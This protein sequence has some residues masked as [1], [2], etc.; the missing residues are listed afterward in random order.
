MENAK[1]LEKGEAQEPEERVSKRTRERERD[2]EQG[3][4]K[5]PNKTVIV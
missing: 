4:W 1:E 3:K 5:S 2:G